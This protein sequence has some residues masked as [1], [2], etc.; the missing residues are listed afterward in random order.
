MID[1]KIGYN[2]SE[3]KPFF[4]ARKVHFSGMLSDDWQQ[5]SKNYKHEKSLIN[6]CKRNNIFLP[7]LVH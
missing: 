6:Y 5:V 7:E 1:Y 3:Q 4:L 2:K